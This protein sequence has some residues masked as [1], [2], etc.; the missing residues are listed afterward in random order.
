MRRAM[1][2]AEVGDDVFGDDP[3][4]IAL[5]E[6]AAELLGKEAGLFVASGTMGNLVVAAGPRRRGQE[7]DRRRASTTW[8][9][10]RRPATRSSSAP[11]I[12][13]RC[14]DRPD[15]TL[16]PHDIDARLPRPDRPARADHGP[17]HAREHP[18]P[19]DGPAAVRRPT[20]GRSPAI[21]HDARRPAAHRRRPVLERGR[22]PGRDRR[23]TSPARPTRSRSAC[24]RAWPARS[25]RSSSARDVHR[26][27]AS[28]P[29]AGRR[30]DAP[31]RDPGGGRARRPV[32]RTRR[33]DRTPGRGPR[34]RAAPG[35]GAERHGRHRVGRRYGPARDRTARPGR[36]SPPTSSLFRVGARPGAV[37]RCAPGRGTC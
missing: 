14:D 19:L 27:G 30:R 12:R 4:V 17:G 16:D 8:S 35:R 2:E 22:R 10:T 24:R 26:T 31:G 37:P 32:R 6:R 7:I 5:E 29:Q 13:G 23:A 18:R 3:T 25:G 33:H 28:R 15:G 20:R 11:A 36:G 21:A 9:S 34:Q 1:A